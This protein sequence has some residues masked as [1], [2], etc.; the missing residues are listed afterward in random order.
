[1]RPKRS[2]KSD[3]AELNLRATR[4]RGVTSKVGEN[5]S[6]FSESSQRVLAKYSS[7]PDSLSLSLSEAFGNREMDSTAPAPSQA[8]NA[9]IA[10]SCAGS[11]RRSAFGGSR[12]GRR[13]H[14]EYKVCRSK[15][16][17]SRETLRPSFPPFLGARPSSIPRVPSVTL[18]P[19]RDGWR[20]SPLPCDPLDGL[21]NDLSDPCL[22][23][24]PGGVPVCSL[25]PSVQDFL[26][27]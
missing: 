1:M 16:N 11:N 7:R 20:V 23:Q 25:L 21:Q 8:S 24:V 10:C 27:F 4:R 26:G 9:C 3:A 15:W 5:S 12:A 22:V 13:D 14:A 6:S 19:F 2:G 17:D 18:K